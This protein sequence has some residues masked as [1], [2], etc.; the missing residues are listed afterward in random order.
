LRLALYLCRNNKC[1]MTGRAV[2]E[3]PPILR[4]ILACTTLESTR[5]M[6]N[7]ITWVGLTNGRTTKQQRHLTVMLASDGLFGQ[8][9]VKDHSVPAVVGE[10]LSHGCTRVRGQELQRRRVG[11]GGSGNGTF[12]HG[13]ALV[14]MTDR[15]TDR[16]TGQWWTASVQHQ[17]KFR[18][19]DRP[20]FSG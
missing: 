10:L 19:V 17:R 16:P 18:R 20:W 11:S 9:I 3:P 14:E 1:E 7:D 12:G 13:S 5:V 8:V 2:N 15:P 6:V 4:F